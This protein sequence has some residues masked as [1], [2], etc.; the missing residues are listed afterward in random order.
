MCF[1][2]KISEG[3]TISN[4]AFGTIKGFSEPSIDGLP[5][6]AYIDG[7]VGG[8]LG[9]IQESESG[10]MLLP[11][12]P[13]VYHRRLD[14]VIPLQQ[15]ENLEVQADIYN[16]M[17]EETQKK[18]TTDQEDKTTEDIPSQNQTEQIL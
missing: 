5:R 7:K 8:K 2:K 11:H 12:H 10:D 6:S 3:L 4:L 18:Q 16:R 14:A 17:I 1:K 9:K 15:Y 13:Y